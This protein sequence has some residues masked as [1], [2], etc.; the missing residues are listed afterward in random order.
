MIEN[1]PNEVWKTITDFPN[2]QVSNMGRVKSLN[3]N[4]TGKEK[5]LIQSKKKNG[6]LQVDL[7]ENKKKKYINVHRLVA[8]HFL[9]NNDL[10]KTEI[11]H[12]SEKKTDNRV[13]N[14]EWIDHK[15]NCNYG[16]RNLRSSK[17]NINHPKKSKQINQYS[18]DGKFI[19]SFQ[20]MS[21]IYRQLN[22]CQTHIC[23]CCKG[24]IN[25][26]YG[27]IWKYA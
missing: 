2:Y 9:P 26:A 4:H 23:R 17:S 20:S 5:L 8:L 7:C 10:S 15:S 22:F 19:R 21:E 12:K 18:I 14:L 24:K 25:T 27:F 1:L 16:T 11:N 6:Y 3:Y 13:E